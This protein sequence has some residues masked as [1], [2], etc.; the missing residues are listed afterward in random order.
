MRAISASAPQVRA[1]SCR[2]RRH[3]GSTNL[4][5]R[6]SGA[7]D[8][9][10]AAQRQEVAVSGVTAELTAARWAYSTIGRQHGCRAHPA[11]LRSLTA[12]KLRVTAS[13]NKAAS[14]PSIGASTH[15]AGGQRAGFAE[16]WA[17]AMPLVD[18]QAEG[19]TRRHRGPSSASKPAR[20]LAAAL[21]REGAPCPGARRAGRAH[22]ASAPPGLEGRI[23]LWRF[24]GPVG[25]TLKRD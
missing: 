1:A 6:L 22:P 13:L 3:Q 7:R 2:I 24:P 16:A 5:G 14:R 25:R 19:P 21:A 17:S 18:A 23:L 15:I 10:T 11:V 8:S 9:L 4:A 20:P 12:I